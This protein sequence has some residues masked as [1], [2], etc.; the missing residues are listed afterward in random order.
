MQAV[1]VRAK[2]RSLDVSAIDA[3]RL[4]TREQLAECNGTGT[5]PPLGRH[6]YE[7]SLLFGNGPFWV[8]NFNM[9]AKPA[10]EEW[11]CERLQ[12]VLDKVGVQQVVVGHTPQVRAH[13]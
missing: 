10:Y 9:W 11:G 13:S 7:K 3:L 5:C 4:F 6:A 12:S 1:S 2:E 8:R